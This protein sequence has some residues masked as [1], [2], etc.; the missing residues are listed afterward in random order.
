MV[1]TFSITLAVVLMQAPAPQGPKVEEVLARYDVTPLVKLYPQ[2]TAKIALDSA[3]KAAEK[4]RF[5][6]VAAHLMDPAFVDSESTVRGRAFAAEVEEALRIR[7]QQEKE[8]S[9]LPRDKRLPDEPEKFQPFIEAAAQA[10]GFLRLVAD[11]REKS[12][13]DPNQ[14]KEL[15]RFVREGVWEESG[16]TAKV[17]LRDVKD[18]AVYLKKIGKRWFVENKMAEEK[19]IQPAGNAP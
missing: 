7:R 11:M 17:T 5:D 18:R 2:T 19:P 10:K 15:R 3:V 9:N 14:L 16:E 6:Y 13:E 12:N 4:G 1:T 8:S